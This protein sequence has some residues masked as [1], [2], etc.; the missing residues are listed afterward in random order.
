MPKVK[1]KLKRKPIPIKLDFI[2]L[3]LFPS[4]IDYECFN[5]HWANIHS[6][7]LNFGFLLEQGKR[8]AI[9]I[10]VLINAKCLMNI[11]LEI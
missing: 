3:N 4:S 9:N 5:F 2:Y 8:T 7:R 1:G 10:D 11:D 6:N